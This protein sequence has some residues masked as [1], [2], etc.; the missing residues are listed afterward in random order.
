MFIPGAVQREAQREERPA[1][2][3]HTGGGGQYKCVLVPNSVPIYVCR[4]LPWYCRPSDKLVEALIAY[5]APGPQVQLLGRIMAAL[6]KAIDP[7][8]SRPPPPPQ[9]ASAVTKGVSPP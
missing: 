8:I 6:A 4:Q 5:P 1:G 2:A 3:V 7:A 9:E